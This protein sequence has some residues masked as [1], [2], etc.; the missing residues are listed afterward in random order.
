MLHW[1]TQLKK[2]PAVLSEWFV[3]TSMVPKK[4]PATLAEIHSQMKGG[5]ITATEKFFLEQSIAN[6][7][8]SRKEYKKF[9]QF[10]G[11]REKGVETTVDWLNRFAFE[12]SHLDGSDKRYSALTLWE[13]VTENNRNV[14]NVTNFTQREQVQRVKKCLA[15]ILQ[16]KDFTKL[17]PFSR[18]KTLGQLLTLHNFS[19]LVDVNAKLLEHLGSI[20]AVLQ[21]LIEQKIRNILPNFPVEQL[22]LQNFLAPVAETFQMLSRAQK[23]G[24]S[25]V[26]LLDNMFNTQVSDSAL[27]GKILELKKAIYLSAKNDHTYRKAD[28]SC[29]PAFVSDLSYHTRPW[30]P[31]EF[32]RTAQV[33]EKAQG[34]NMPIDSEYLESAQGKLKLPAAKKVYSLTKPK[35]TVPNFSSAQN[36]A[37][38]QQN[39]S[40]QGSD[41]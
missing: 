32:L 11:W 38:T 39:L 4:T 27:F 30:T 23:L 36:V 5:P 22:E 2:K 26:E 31:T 17:V 8:L 14:Q 24:M 7:P 18:I 40:A 20:L 25:N 21:A 6:S 10:S 12:N 9:M 28:K 1:L 34:Y 35:L 16:S 29:L 37:S 13:L 3:Q 41:Q 33:S 15:A 19:D